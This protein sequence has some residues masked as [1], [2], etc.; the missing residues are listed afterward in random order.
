[1]PISESSI[2]KSE[3]REIEDCKVYLGYQVDQL[4]IGV[5]T[6]F[7]VPAIESMPFADLPFSGFFSKSRY[8]TDRFREALRLIGCGRGLR[9]ENSVSMGETFV[10][11]E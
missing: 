10:H 5:G 11:N 2:I 4:M 1:M 6:L 7:Q 8:F 3:Q 9:T